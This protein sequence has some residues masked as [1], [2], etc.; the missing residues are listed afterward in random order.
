MTF[1]LQSKGSVGYE[2]DAETMVTV[3]RGGFA[4]VEEQEWVGPVVDHKPSKYEVD[5]T[6]FKY[7][8]TRKALDSFVTQ[9]VTPSG[10]IKYHITGVVFGRGGLGSVDVAIP[11]A[12]AP[13]V[14]H[15]SQNH[16]MLCMHPVSG[17]LTLIDLESTKG[18]HVTIGDKVYKLG[19]D[20][21]STIVSS[22][23]LR[24]P[25]YVEYQDYSLAGTVRS[26]IQVDTSVTKKQDKYVAREG[27]IAF[28][29]AM[30]F[31][32]DDELN[33]VFCRRIRDTTTNNL[34]GF[35]PKVISEMLG[36]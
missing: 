2:L 24:R 9:S 11:T 27:L 20:N 23:R 21:S 25:I 13:K 15:V 6:K 18:T 28:L 36:C 4:V 35:M 19:S 7:D 16:F 31:G 29:L 32:K 12:M 3:Q 34:Y 17:V 5:L 30:R 1:P 33:F 22:F 26:I 14:E 10:V 8:I